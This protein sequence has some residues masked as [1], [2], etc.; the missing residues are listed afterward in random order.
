MSRA[1][2]LS[3]LALGAALLG[4]VVVTATPASAGNGYC[5]TGDLCLYYE[6]NWRGGSHG[7][8]ESGNYTPNRKFGGF[9]GDGQQVKNNA[10]SVHN[11]DPFKYVTVYY[12]SNYDDSVA[13]ETIA[14]MTKANLGGKLKNENASQQF[15]SLSAPRKPNL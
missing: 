4:S 10:E 1:R 13:F 12:N 5:N 8:G 2:K 9:E 15:R 14:P 6:S 11:F 7:M 3:A